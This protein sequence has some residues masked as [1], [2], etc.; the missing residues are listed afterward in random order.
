MNKP[1][2]EMQVARLVEKGGVPTLAKAQDSEQW[3]LSAI[4]QDNEA[5][6][7]A[8]DEAVARGVTQSCFAL[9]IHAAIWEVVESMRD[10]HLPVLVAPY[11]DALRMAGYEE[12]EH[13]AR[14]L[15]TLPVHLD[16]AALYAAKVVEAAQV[17]QMQVT[18]LEVAYHGAALGLR[19]VQDRLDECVTGA[20]RQ[21]SASRRKPASHLMQRWK[22]RMQS[23]L[24]GQLSLGIPTHIEG[25]D[26]LIDGG[27]QDGRIYY[28]GGAEKV[29]K[30]RLITALAST[31]LSQGCAV[32]W[33]SVEMEEL[34][35]IDFLIAHR[36]G[37]YTSEVNKI[38]LGAGLASR[39]PEAE[40]RFIRDIVHEANGLAVN[41]RFHVTVLEDE[42][43][44]D[45]YALVR[46]GVAEHRRDPENGTKPYVVIVDYVQDID[47]G[48]ATGSEAEKIK[49]VSKRLRTM[50]KA[51]GVAV[52]GVFH[53]NRQAAEVEPRPHHVFGSS[54]L[55]K[56][57]DHML[58][59]WRPG[60]GNSEV[61]PDWQN[62]LCIIAALNRRG[63][64]GRTHL[65]AD[66]GRCRYSAW[67]KGD[68]YSYVGN[69]NDDGGRSW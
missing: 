60:Y 45:I 58:L 18:A 30:T 8:Y 37:Y 11:I 55:Q 38:K 42:S 69:S 2:I 5:E 39:S 33:Y 1:T 52:V 34:D 65:R 31:C 53:T 29:G 35:P 17:R 63:E 26:E 62:Y 13:Y 47:P 44:R 56:D 28:I 36:A 64:T 21:R 23:R 66:L 41:K 9:P 59:L 25:L 46:M 61:H 67:D 19:D 32:D 50:A 57:C 7:R 68:W 43:V 40:D 15:W 6:W 27:I 54:Q 48:K 4:V 16:N 14:E 22:E 49:E 10:A 24:S 12:Y 20:A 51:L 3:L